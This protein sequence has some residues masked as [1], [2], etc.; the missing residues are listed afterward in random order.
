MSFNCG[1]DC[2]D[3]RENCHHS[4]TTE[5]GECLL[6]N[7]ERYGQTWRYTANPEDPCITCVEWRVI[8]EELGRREPYLFGGRVVPCVYNGVCDACQEAMDKRQGVFSDRP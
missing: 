7:F 8:D 5:P 1:H 2:C 4:H 6:C 3:I